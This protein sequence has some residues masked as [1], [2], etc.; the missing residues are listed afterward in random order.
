MPKLVKAEYERWAK[1][2]KSVLKGRKLWTIV[3]N[4]YVPIDTKAEGVT[5]ERIAEDEKKEADN[6]SALA[7]LQHATIHD[8]NLFDKI[9]DSE[10]AKEIWEILEKAFRSND[11]VRK[12]T[13]QNLGRRTGGNPDEIWRKRNRVH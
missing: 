8:N 3:E 11:R 1:L 7:L 2:A 4:G 13:L 12:L 9:G 5:P 10:S 6:A